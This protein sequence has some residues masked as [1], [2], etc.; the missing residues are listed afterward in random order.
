MAVIDT[1]FDVLSASVGATFGVLV[2]FVLNRKSRQ[3]MANQVVLSRAELEK[4]KLENSELLK[5][6]QDKENTILQMQMQILDDD[7]T[8]KGASQKKKPRRTKK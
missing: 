3:K 4:I 7:V 8:D 1:F 5:R 2:G 6:V